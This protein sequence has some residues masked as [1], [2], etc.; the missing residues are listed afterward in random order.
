M[1]N[2]VLGAFQSN[3]DS[4]WQFVVFELDQYV[5]NQNTVCQK[6]ELEL[7]ET[8][9][10]TSLQAGASAAVEGFEVWGLKRLKGLATA[11]SAADSLVCMVALSFRN[12]Q[13]R[14]A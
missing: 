9:F 1:F 6:A 7:S 14:A 10:S 3:F 12:R 8:A 13:V 4:V 2:G 5:C 11:A